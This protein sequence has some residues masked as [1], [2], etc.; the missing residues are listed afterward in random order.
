MFK[1]PSMQRWQCVIDNATFKIFARSSMIEILFFCFLKLLVFHMRF[2]C[3]SDVRNSCLRKAIEELSELNTFRVRLRFQ[4][5][6]CKS[7]S[8]TFAK[9]VPWRFACSL[10]CCV[11]FLIF[12]SMLKHDWTSLYKTYENQYFL[13]IQR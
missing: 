7:G 8:A 4:G 11:F 2:L 9:R 1:W 5:Y 13:V 6:H 3:K 10:K 12:H